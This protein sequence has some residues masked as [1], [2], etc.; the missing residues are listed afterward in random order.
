MWR[1]G[2]ISAGREPSNVLHAFSIDFVKRCGDFDFFEVWSV[3]IAC[4]IRSSLP[5]LLLA[6]SCF[7]PLSL[8]LLH[9]EQQ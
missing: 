7:C 4:R 5:P 3:R 6:S 2:E 9:D 8:F 1:I